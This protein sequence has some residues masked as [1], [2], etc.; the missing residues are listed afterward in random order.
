MMRINF[1]YDW[2]QRKGSHG[3]TLWLEGMNL[4]NEIFKPFSK[5][6]MA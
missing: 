3:A 4:P 6:L 5:S 2:K 1:F